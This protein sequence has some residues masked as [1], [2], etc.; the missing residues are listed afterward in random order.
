MIL[1]SHQCLGLAHRSWPNFWDRGSSAN[2]VS[3]PCDIILSA[4][5]LWCHWG[6]HWSL[7]VLGVMGCSFLKVSSAFRWGKGFSVQEGYESQPG[8]GSYC[9]GFPYLCHPTTLG[10]G[11]PSSGL[12]GIRALPWPVA[13]LQQD[14][15]GS[16]SWGGERVLLVI[17]HHRA[18]Q[19]V[20]LLVPL[21]FLCGW[22]DCH[23]IE[24]RF[25][26]SSWHHD[27]ENI[28]QVIPWVIHGTQPGFFPCLISLPF[29]AWWPDVQCPEDFLFHLFFLVF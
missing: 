16:A 7:M 4:C 9:G 24:G 15:L 27:L 11:M 5:F 18:F 3:E 25:S 29:I 22:Q 10:G 2:F 6:S 21:S 23:S 20:R 28:L 8:P 26:F 17:Q 1:G 12:A 19:S 13:V 14:P